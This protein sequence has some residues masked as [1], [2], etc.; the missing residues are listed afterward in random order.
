MVPVG[1]DPGTKPPSFEHHVSDADVTM[2]NTANFARGINRFAREVIIWLRIKMSRSHTWK[3]IAECGDVLL[4][5]RGAINGICKVFKEPVVME[6]PDV[7][8]DNIELLLLRP[9]E[10]SCL[11]SLSIGVDIPT[12]NI[13]RDRRDSSLFKLPTE[14]SLRNE[15]I[16]YDAPRVL[17]ELDLVAAQN[18]GQVSPSRTSKSGMN[19]NERTLYQ[20]ILVFMRDVVVNGDL[21]HRKC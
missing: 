2:E 4:R 6:V 3:T 7:H 16:M 21:V 18:V 9:V 17:Q 11:F 14:G 19:T 20:D 5:V 1:Q 15:T 13:L 8:I 12:E 10:T